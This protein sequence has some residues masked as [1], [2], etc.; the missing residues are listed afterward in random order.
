MTML[1]HFRDQSSMNFG[2]TN[3]VSRYGRRRSSSPNRASDLGR[4]LYQC[5]E[6]QRVRLFYKI[7]R[8]G[9]NESSRSIYLNHFNEDND[10]KDTS[11]GV[12][13]TT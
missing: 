7:L 3:L 5:P 6:G 11:D 2:H 8:P 1:S 10:E 13:R 4:I 9:V 12:Y